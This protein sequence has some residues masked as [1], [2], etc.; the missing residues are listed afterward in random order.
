VVT[1]PAGA[2]GDLLLADWTE[3]GLLLPQVQ[4]PSFSFECGGHMQIKSFLEVGFP[5]RIVWVGLCANFRMPLN[6]D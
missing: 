2:L 4:K 3:T 6:A 5:A 1:V